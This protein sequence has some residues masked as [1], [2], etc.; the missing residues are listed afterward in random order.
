MAARPTFIHELEQLH[1]EL[2]KMGALVEQSIEKATEAF[3][4]QNCALAKE[5]V[6]NDRQINDIERTIEAKCL[7]LIL[8]QQPVATDL[9]NVS[10]ALKIVTDME[11][12]GDQSADISDLSIRLM[13]EN[14]AQMVEHIPA[15]ARVAKSMVHDAIHAFIDQDLELAEQVIHRDDELDS[16]FDQVKQDLIDI[17]KVSPELSDNC[18][19]I[20]MIAKY[21]ERTG[22]H[23]VNICEWAEFSKTGLLNDTK[24]I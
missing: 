2:V 16:L 4:T 13:G 14:I 8:R 10:S 12:I 6:V 19:D 7:S 20:L 22:D 15:M 9:R 5:T 11:R 18:I 1:I 17:L 3:L 21:L 23:A 24:L